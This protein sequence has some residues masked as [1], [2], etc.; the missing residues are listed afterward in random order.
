MSVTGMQ[1]IK[2]SQIY[3]GIKT[4]KCVGIHMIHLMIYITKMDQVWTVDTGALG[5]YHSQQV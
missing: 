3:E 2:F 5:F 4:T 1:N